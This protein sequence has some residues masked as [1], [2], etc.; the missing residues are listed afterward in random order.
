MAQ[1]FVILAAG[2]GSRLNHLTSFNPKP[3]VR[4]GDKLLID[5]AL[6]N[7]K[8]HLPEVDITIIISGYKKEVLEKYI[9]DIAPKYSFELYCVPA[10]DYKKGN[11]RSLL[12]VEPY[13]TDRFFLAMCDHLFEG[14]H[15]HVIEREFEEGFDLSLCI[16]FTPNYNIQLEDATKVF[17]DRDNNILHIG[18]NLLTWTAIDTGLFCLSP[19]IFKR[20]KQV[21]KK[22]VTITDGVTQMIRHGDF[23]RGVDV[24]GFSWADID[25][26]TDLRN[27]E[28]HLLHDVNPPFSSPEEEIPESADYRL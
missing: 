18:K 26:F 21:L 6:D 15:Y 11:G 23:V 12:A 10:S 19:C 4:L 16:D 20:L 27:A 24:S 28:L 5:Y 7:I 9:E 1:T 22:H 3:L 25:T 14:T 8:N 13:V 2:L 17:T